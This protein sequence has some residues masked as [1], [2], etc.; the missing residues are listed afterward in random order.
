MMVENPSVTPSLER[1]VNNHCD[2]K[3]TVVIF[4]HF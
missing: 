1:I 3:L 2:L 4:G